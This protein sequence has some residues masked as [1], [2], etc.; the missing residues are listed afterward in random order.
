MGQGDGSLLPSAHWNVEL[1]SRVWL[2]R[3]LRLH[4]AQCLCRTFPQTREEAALI[5]L[6]IVQDHISVT[7]QRF[8]S[9]LL[10]HQGLK[11]PA[12]KGRKIFKGTDR[13]CS[14]LLQ[15]MQKYLPSSFIMQRKK[16]YKIITWN[17]EK[18][19]YKDQFG[20]VSFDHTIQSGPKKKI[21]YESSSLSHAK[22]PHL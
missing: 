17:T 1:Y 2:D 15:N 19:C 20:Q 5:L 6:Q 14:T 3:S 8:S 22:L 18:L 13:S 12:A 10:R 16:L 11:P 7:Q 9:W 4:R 21:K